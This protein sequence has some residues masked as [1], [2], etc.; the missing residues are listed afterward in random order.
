MIW[1]FFLFLRPCHMSY[2]ILVAILLYTHSL[3]GW[4]PTDGHSLLLNP[5]YCWS[6]KPMKSQ[7]ISVLHREVFLACRRQWNPFINL[8]YIN[9]SY[10]NPMNPI[11]DPI[12]SSIVN[13]NHH[14]PSINGIF[15]PW[16]PWKKIRVA[17]SITIPGMALPWKTRRAISFSVPG[18][19]S[20][21]KESVISQSF[22]PVMETMAGLGAAWGLV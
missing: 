18:S 1:R 21:S 7:Q 11:V 15:I 19:K 4:Y 13:P 22:R 14:N 2:C 8:S 3:H 17:M 12:N 20:G 5:Y 10:I 16:V 9:P 6:K